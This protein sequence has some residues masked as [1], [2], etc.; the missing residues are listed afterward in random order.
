MSHEENLLFAAFA[1]QLSLAPLPQTLEATAAWAAEPSLTIPSAFASN[2]I[3]REG[4]DT[5]GKW[6]R[7]LWRRLMATRSPRSKR[8][9]SSLAFGR[10]GASR[11]GRC[12]AKRASTP[13]RY[14]GSLRDLADALIHETPG[15][16]AA[17][18][19]TPAAAWAG[20]FWSTTPTWAAISR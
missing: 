16:Y 4:R 19:N 14:G 5:L 20:Y 18:A 13:R 12:G 8:H 10:Y 3:T 11:P 15:R 1:V 6:S 7:R 2:A 9:P 17:T